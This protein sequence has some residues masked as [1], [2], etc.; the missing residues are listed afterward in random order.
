[1]TYVDREREKKLTIGMRASGKRQ[2]VRTAMATHDKVASEVGSEISHRT[3]QRER[4]LLWT[5]EEVGE[6]GSAQTRWWLL[7]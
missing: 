7:C 5:V 4:W 1:M 3:K 6:S 2:P